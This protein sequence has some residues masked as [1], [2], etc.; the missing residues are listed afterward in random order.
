MTVTAV[1]IAR[2]GINSPSE[3]NGARDDANTTGDGSPDGHLSDPDLETD[4]RFLRATTPPSAEN[5]RL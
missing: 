3:F 2:F 5:G 4:L 1:H